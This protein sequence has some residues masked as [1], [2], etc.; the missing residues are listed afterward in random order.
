MKAPVTS[1]LLQLRLH[2]FRQHD[3]GHGSAQ[4]ENESI[5]EAS[6]RGILTIG[7][8]ATQQTRRTAAKARHLQQAHHS[9]LRPRSADPFVS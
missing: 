8:A 5:D 7:A 2:P 9:C 4:E 6:H 3:T 1:H